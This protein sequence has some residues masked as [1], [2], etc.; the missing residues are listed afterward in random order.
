[1]ICGRFILPFEAEAVRSS[2]QAHRVVEAVQDECKVLDLI[3]LLLELIF[4]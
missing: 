2:H 3:E 4:A 1:M